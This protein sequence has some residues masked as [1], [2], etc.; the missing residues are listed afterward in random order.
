MVIGDYCAGK[1]F[2]AAS[3]NFSDAWNNM[4]FLLISE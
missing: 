4:V 2:V 1:G 3:V